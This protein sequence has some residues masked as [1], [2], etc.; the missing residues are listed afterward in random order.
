MANRQGVEALAHEIISSAH[1]RA[2]EMV[3]AARAR[4]ADEVRRAEE[5]AAATRARV[6]GQAQLEAAQER[7]RIEAAA[8]MEARQH[9][10]AT[11]EALISRVLEEARAQLTGGLSPQERRA[12]LEKAVFASAAALGGGRLTVRTNRQDAPFLT[13]EL[14]EGLT[15]RLAAR[16]IAAELEPGPTADI[17]GGAIVT[18]DGGRVIIDHSFDARLEQHLLELRN[19]AWEVLREAV[20]EW[21]AL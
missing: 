19:Q 10:L 18:G 11:R 1:E 2:D 16:G 15:R 4:A 21:V 13:P 17:L 14:L 20:P 8:R 5:E 3:A 6:V 12:A 7:T 9:I